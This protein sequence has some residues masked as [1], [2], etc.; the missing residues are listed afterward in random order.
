MRPDEVFKM[1][2]RRR[3]VLPRAAEPEVKVS[4]LVK[5]SI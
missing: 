4:F 3:P 5:V 2:G 1:M